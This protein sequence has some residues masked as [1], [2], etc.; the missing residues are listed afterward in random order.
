MKGGAHSASGG[1]LKRGAHSSS[2]GKILKV[3][4]HSSSGGE[5]L[6]GGAHVASGGILVHSASGRILAHSARGRVLAHSASAEILVYSASGRILTGDSQFASGERFLHT[7]A[8][9]LMQL[10][11]FF[12]RLIL[13]L[14]DFLWPPSQK[15]ETLATAKS[16]RK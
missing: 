3:G 10:S 6:I 5:I 9:V 13:E 11:L 16:P 2:G 4:A 12:L 14:L 7:K 8:Q 15:L 1:I